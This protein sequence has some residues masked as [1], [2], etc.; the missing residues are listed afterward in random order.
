MN[1][2]KSMICGRLTVQPQMKSTPS[3]KS[4]VSFGLAI[5]RT[6]SDSAG[7]KQQSV[8]FV[9]VVFWG[10]NAEVLSQY[11]V[12]GQ[13]IFVEGR[14]ATR[15]Y[16]KNGEKRYITEIVGERFQFGQKPM[17]GAQEGKSTTMEVEGSPENV[18]GGFGEQ[19]NEDLPF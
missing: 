7:K 1:V 11:A 3:G 14:I 19:G 17:G 5:N 9:N 18:S 13:V 15:T 16:D 12:K 10:K 4:V 2:N 8:E 6:W